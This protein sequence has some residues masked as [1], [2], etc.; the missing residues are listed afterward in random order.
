MKGR[1]EKSS[2]HPSSFILPP[3]DVEE[4]TDQFEAVAAQLEALLAEPLAQLR[5][6]A[7]EQLRL[8]G[9][10]QVA[11]LTG[12]QAAE[13]VMGIAAPVVASGAVVAD[14]TRRH[15]RLDERLQ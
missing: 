8:V 6:E 10:R 3:F 14:Q 5:R 12:G 11:D 13:M 1:Q 9:Q 7:I 4:S 2:F 15:A